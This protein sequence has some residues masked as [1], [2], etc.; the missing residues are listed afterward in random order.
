VGEFRINDH[1]GVE[2]ARH[3]ALWC[4][5]SGLIYTLGSRNVG[6]S[7]RRFPVRD[8]IGLSLPLVINHGEVVRLIDIAFSVLD[9]TQRDLHP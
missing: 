5:Y 2:G 3:R 7:K 9:F 1:K 6:T 4:Y 8:V